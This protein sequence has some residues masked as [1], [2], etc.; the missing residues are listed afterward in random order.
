MGEWS[1]EFLASSLSGQTKTF[2]ETESGLYT[3][4]LANAK[5]NRKS[6]EVLSS[7]IDVKCSMAKIVKLNSAARDSAKLRFLALLS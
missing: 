5:E 3:L 4:F 1:E 2:P 7:I 6:V